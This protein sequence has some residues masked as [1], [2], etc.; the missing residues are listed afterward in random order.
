MI[1]NAHTAETKMLKIGNEFIERVWEQGREK[2]FK[3]VGI[4]LD[5]KLKWSHHISY[6]LKKVNSSNYVLTRSSKTLNTKNKRL[7]YSGLVHSHLVYGLLIW[8]MPHQA[9]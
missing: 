5:E 9:G 6:I 4:Q 1:F 7:I 8:G 3:L 2:S